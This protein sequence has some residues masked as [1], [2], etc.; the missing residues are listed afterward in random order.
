MLAEWR[1]GKC[2]LTGI[3]LFRD[4]IQTF[5]NDNVV[6]IVHLEYTKQG[7][8]FMYEKGYCNDIGLSQYNCKNFALTI[9][10]GIYI[11]YANFC[12]IVLYMDLSLKNA[13]KSFYFHSL[14]V[15]FVK[16]LFNKSIAYHDTV[17]EYNK[18]RIW[19][20]ERMI[21]PVLF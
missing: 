5:M 2:T 14:V 13:L 8:K 20:Q 19:T 9:S 10:F 21:F 15:L 18:A 7:N 11:W 16:W 3:E 4:A 12:V 6:T 1:L 17:V